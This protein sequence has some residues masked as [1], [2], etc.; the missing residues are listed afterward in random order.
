[1]SKFLSSF[2]LGILVLSLAGCGEKDNN[3]DNSDIVTDVT[4]TQAVTETGI[5][6]KS[7]TGETTVSETGEQKDNSVT[8]TVAL[9]Q[10]DDGEIIIIDEN[11]DTQIQNSVSDNSQESVDDQPDMNIDI[12]EDDDGVIVLPFI[13]L[14]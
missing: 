5:T 10:N 4:S 3:S 1:M 11:H 8:T 14:D 2:L 7:V 6:E 13:P 12:S 9:I